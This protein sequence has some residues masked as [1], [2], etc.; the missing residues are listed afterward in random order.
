MSLRHW[1]L[2]AVIGLSIGWVLFVP[3]VALPYVLSWFA[4]HPAAAGGDDAGMVGIAFGPQ[5]MLFVAVAM[6]LP[7]L[8]LLLLWSRAH[9]HV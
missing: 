6:V 9:R 8:L 7:P 1:P 4:G 5:E 2:S 3:I